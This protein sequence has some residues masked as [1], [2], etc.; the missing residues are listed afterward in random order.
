MLSEVI[1]I[2]NEQFDS[3]PLPYDRVDERFG[4][5]KVYYEQIQEERD[6]DAAEYIKTIAKAIYDLM[7]KEDINTIHDIAFAI[8][9][10]L[11]ID[12]TLENRGLSLKRYIETTLMIND[13]TGRDALKYIYYFGVLVVKG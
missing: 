8:G 5:I 12:K 9:L 10:Q 7:I 4:K 1:E 2:S 3:F 6:R 13:P 11:L